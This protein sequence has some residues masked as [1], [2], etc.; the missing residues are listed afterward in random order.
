MTSAVTYAETCCQLYRF[1]EL[2]GR[3]DITDEEKAQLVAVKIL[4]QKVKNPLHYRINGVRKL[5]GSKKNEPEL[6]PH[7]QKVIK[8]CFLNCVLIKPYSFGRLKILDR[9]E[10]ICENE[11]SIVV[12]QKPVKDLSE[13]NTKSVVEFS[14]SSY[15]VLENEGVCHMS[16]ERYGKIDNEISFRFEIIIRI[17]WNGW[18]G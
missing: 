10:S 8:V 4:N 18:F 7:L 14:V 15:A 1:Q 11:N 12:N 17:I 9:S 3:N 6:P 16:I 13:N 2:D 5:T